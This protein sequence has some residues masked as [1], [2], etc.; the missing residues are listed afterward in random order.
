MKIL[1]I[2]RENPSAAAAQFRAYARA[3]AARAWELYQAG[4]I[5]ELYFCADRPQAVLMLECAGLDEAQAALATL[6]LVEHGL[7]TFDLY[8]LAAYPGFARLFAPPHDFPGDPA[9]SQ[10]QGTARPTGIGI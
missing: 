5:R 3:E 6:P 4:V 2:E 7:I 10:D 9:V 8:P 1:A